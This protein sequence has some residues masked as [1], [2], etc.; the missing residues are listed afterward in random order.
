MTT[1]NVPMER[2]A[3]TSK[4]RCNLRVQYAREPICAICNVAGTDALPPRLAVACAN[5]SAGLVDLTYSQGALTVL[6]V[7]HRVD[8]PQQGPQTTCC[9][10]ARGLGYLISA[11]VG[12]QVVAHPL[13][14]M[15]KP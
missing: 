1:D 13:D 10:A 2:M 6:T 8:V 11:G 5:G 4:L 12:G 3:S 14:S 15:G 9:F 7:R